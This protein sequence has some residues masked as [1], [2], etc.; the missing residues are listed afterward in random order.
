M[1]TFL[2]F[3]VGNCTIWDILFG[4][5]ILCSEGFIT[6]VEGNC[7]GDGVLLGG[8]RS[9]CWPTISGVRSS[10]FPFFTRLADDGPTLDV[11]GSFLIFL[12][13]TFLGLLF[14]IS[15]SLLSDEACLFLAAD[16]FSFFK[17]IWIFRS[18]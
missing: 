3:E 1:G 16:K 11:W 6:L 14:I 4:D 5:I 2:E 10:S 8:F 9:F 17:N 15:L 12:V 18:F 7:L 13:F